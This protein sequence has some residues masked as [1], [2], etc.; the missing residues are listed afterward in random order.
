MTDNRPEKT[1]LIIDDEPHNLR[2][3]V[4]FL[5]GQGFR[6]LISQDGASGL[7]RAA[8]AQPDLI[9]LDAILPDVDGFTLCQQLKANAETKEIP[10]LFLTILTVPADRLKAIEVGAAD[11]ITKPVQWED[12]LLRV[13]TQLHIRDLTR[14]LAHAEAQLAQ[15]HIQA[16][17]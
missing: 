3:M 7:Q 10:I 2:M 13:N 12:V 16:K 17:G 8:Y 6:V 14:R 5:E 11:Y 4:E 15:V 1:I 9:L